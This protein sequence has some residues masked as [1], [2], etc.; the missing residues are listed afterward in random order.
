MTDEWL[1]RLAGA[2]MQVDQQFNDRVVNSQFSNQQWGLIMTAVE[3]DI[4]NPGKPGDA[5]LVARTDDIEK[6]LPELE[7][8]EQGMMGATPQP[9]RRS[10]GGGLFSQLRSFLPGGE[11][12]SDGPDEEQLDAATALV[13][14]YTTEL[15]AY[16]E[17]EGRWDDICESAARST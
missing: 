4:E 16:L 13:E 2:R 9:E 12:T 6:I 7:N 11:D 5:A 14:E 17:A 8:V 1:D 10:S 15:Q 3:F